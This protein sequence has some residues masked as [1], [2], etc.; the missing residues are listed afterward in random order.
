MKEEESE[1]N[2]KCLTYKNEEKT[3]FFLCSGSICEFLLKPLLYL[4]LL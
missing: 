3:S 4:A 1:V 2:V